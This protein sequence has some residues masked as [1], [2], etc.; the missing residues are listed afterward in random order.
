MPIFVAQD[1]D[2]GQTQKFQIRPDPDPQL[3]LEAPL[4]IA[5][6]NRLLAS[7][8]RL[9]NLVPCVSDA[10]NDFIKRLSHIIDASH[11][12]KRYVNFVTR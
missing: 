11:R 10:K 1:P 12:P 3:W 9:K 4:P 6:V 5:N 7:E 8:N 2:Q